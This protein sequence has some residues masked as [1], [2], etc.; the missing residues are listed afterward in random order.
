[1]S[2]KSSGQKKKLNSIELGIYYMPGIMLGSRNSVVNNK[3]IP[4][5]WERQLT[6]NFRCSKRYECGS[7]KYLNLT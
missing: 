5:S 3:D 4:L 1:M 2:M 6:N 7:K